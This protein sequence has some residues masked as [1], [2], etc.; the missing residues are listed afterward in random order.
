[1]K[2]MLAIK[3]QNCPENWAG[4]F[5]L[6]DNIVPLSLS[7]YQDAIWATDRTFLKNQNENWV[8]ADTFGG[9]LFSLALGSQVC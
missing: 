7:T 2:K 1:M 8:F 5:W 9:Y 3:H 6:E 4:I